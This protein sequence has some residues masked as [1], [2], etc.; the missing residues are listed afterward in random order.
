ML[1]ERIAERLGLLNKHG[2]ML[3]GRI[4][5]VRKE[6]EGPRCPAY[7]TDK[8]HAKAVSAA[9]KHFPDLDLS[10]ATNTSLSPLKD[11]ILKD[12]E[13]WYECTVYLMDFRAQTELLMR[14]MSSMLAPLTL[15]QHYDAFVLTLDLL[16]VFYSCI[17]AYMGTAE[18]RTLVYVY[19]TA[20]FQATGCLEENFQ[21][22]AVFLK[23][24]MDPTAALVAMFGASSSLIGSMLRTLDNHQI[25]LGLNGAQYRLQSSYSPL[26]GEGTG[27]GDRVA[28]E[29]LLGLQRINQW[30][31]VGYVLC[32]S[33]LTNES[34]WNSARAAMLYS[35][36]IRIGQGYTIDVVGQLTTLSQ[37]VAKKSSQRRGSIDMQGSMSPAAWHAQRRAYFHTVLGEWHH[38]LLDQPSLSALHLP[39]LLSCLSAAHGEIMWYFMHQSGSGRVPM[40]DLDHTV[41]HLLWHVDALIRQITAQSKDIARYGVELLHTCD[42]SAVAAQFEQLTVCTADESTI[43]A[44]LMDDLKSVQDRWNEGLA[45]DMK[46]WRLD[47]MRLQTAT[48]RTSVST[49]LNRVPALIDALILAAGHSRLVDDL[50]GMLAEVAD[51]SL[52]GCYIPLLRDMMEQCLTGTTR[53]SVASIFLSIHEHF[54]SPR[55]EP[56]QLS[57]VGRAA[58]GSAMQFAE[59]L[60]TTACQWIVDTCMARVVLDAQLL[61]S[62]AGMMVRQHAGVAKPGKILDPKEAPDRVYV[63][64]GSEMLKGVSAGMKGLHGVL[65]AVDQLLEALSTVPVLSVYDTAISPASFLEIA[66]KA[67]FPRVLVRLARTRIGDTVESPGQPTRPSELQW[68]INAFHR[69][70]Q[71]MEVAGGFRASHVYTSTMAQQGDPSDV[72]GPTLASIYIPWY[73]EFARYRLCTPDI[74][75]A[76]LQSCFMSKAT[77]EV[78]AEDYTDV[79]ELS[80]LSSLLGP[81]GITRLQTNLLAIAVGRLKHIF[82]IAG[83]NRDGIGSVQKLITGTKE[84]KVPDTIAKISGLED[85]LET[86][87]HVGA[88]LELHSNMTNAQSHAV[89]TPT[90]H[91]RWPLQPEVDG[92]TPE[93]MAQLAILFAALTAHASMQPSTRFHKGLDALDNNSH[94]LLVT[95]YHVLGPSSTQ[96]SRPFAIFVESATVL[97]L[98]LRRDI[99]SLSVEAQSMLAVLDKFVKQL[100]TNQ[101]SD[102]ARWIPAPLQ[103]DAY[104]VAHTPTRTATQQ[105]R[106]PLG[107]FDS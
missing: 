19:V 102:I 13:R 81:Q 76:P 21:K 11:T 71:H 2:S 49:G 26:H 66:L 100:P 10:A 18:V 104:F 4:C 70:L 41:W 69:A 107:V 93:T 101:T 6:L 99:G 106:K 8:Q 72:D 105:V 53:L 97:L 77:A 73:T 63:P 91:R 47:C 15:R 46:A 1:D 78:R 31:L 25:L 96:S 98:R 24:W 56:S 103:F 38:L 12:L 82:N 20:H 43:L 55:L 67:A 30:V 92:R 52:L 57:A 37:L 65:T 9:T 58:V 60:A 39:D 44:S 54:P 28:R 50:D 87:K 3:L 59:A 64:V 84:S 33:E 85:A 48:A 74:I 17:Q 5:T 88:V 95:A 22:V 75:Y 89:V 86:T 32:P 62:N 61:P 16:V 34:S 90:V 79:N 51:L 7:L 80:C 40:A 83:A 45:V 29:K 68:A 14:D 35:G 94:L 23:Q 42:L 27:W 36:P